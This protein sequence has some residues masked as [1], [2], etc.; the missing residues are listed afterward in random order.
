MS[1]FSFFEDNYKCINSSIFLVMLEK[2]ICNVEKM[3]RFYQLF[4]NVSVALI[5]AREIRMSI[6]FF[7]CLF[8]FS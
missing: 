7:V 1:N 6:M 3:H 5:V 8:V 2:K 4:K